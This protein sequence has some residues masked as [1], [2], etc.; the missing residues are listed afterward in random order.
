[1]RTHAR[2]VVIGGGV[3]GVSTLYHLAKK[4]WSDSVLIERRELTS[5]STWHA[6]GLLP[7]FN[8]SYSV[9]QIHKYSVALYQTLEQE[10][11]L[12]PGLRQVSNI[13]LART[14]DRM[15][16]Y[17]YY[18][19]VA[20][21]IGVKVKF[22][23]PGEVKEIWPLCDVEGIIGAIQHP[24]DG[25]IQPA[26]LTQALARGARDRGAEI[27]RHTTV[28]AVERL[29]SGE[30]K[31]STDKGDVT[32]EHVVSATGNFARQTGRLVGI[33]VPVIPV[34]HQYIVTEAHPEI[35]KRKAQGLPEMGVLR[36]SDSAWYMR[37]E[38]GGLLLGPYEK[39]APACY[40]NGPSSVSE[41][42]LFPEDLDR[43]APHIETA[44]ARVPAFG[45][46][47]VKKVYNGAIAYTPD[48][49][50]IVGPAPG[51]RNF[52]LN[53][54]HS[55]G[56]TAAGG[57]GWQLAEWIVEGE[58]TIDMLGVDPR[59]FGPY[60]DTG[61]L[62]EKNEEAY[63]K[64]FTVHYPDEERAAA[65]PLR[66]TPCYG[67]MKDL[68]AVFGSVYGWERPNW[69]APQGYG[70]S[71]ADLVQPDVL[72]NENHPAVSLGEKPRE[73]WSFRRS[74]Y[75]RFVGDECRNVHENVGLMDMSAFAKCEVSGP[76]AESWL[77][78]ILTNSVP[79][80]I[81]RVTLTYLLTERGGVRAEFT[82]TRIGPERFYLISAGALET[83]DFDV[84]EKL[85]PADNSVRLDKVTTQRGV[86]V[87]AGPR[88][89]EALAKVA[90]ID[91][92]SKAF[93]WLT[94]RRLSIK[95]AGVIAMR[96]NFVGEL[97]YE[98]H[99]PIEMQNAIFDALMAAG[100]PFGVKPFGIRA[101]DSLRLEKSYKLV[102]RELSI[103][104]AALESDL[105]RF[106]DFDKGPFLGR[107]ALVAWKGRGFANRLVTLEVQGVTDA[108]ARGSEPV[109]K[110]GEMIGR[111]TSGGYGWRTGKSL[112]LAMVK[113]EFSRIGDEVDVRILGETRRAIVIPDS[114]YDPA[115][116]ALRA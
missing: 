116:A 107:E 83:H 94:A 103:E 55:F 31:V 3:V 16:E 108:D 53:E 72:L 30:W 19:G 87:L 8:L 90:D 52:W 28:T 98:L 22:L 11:G 13:R 32:C 25:Y 73:K 18:A 115:N 75:F 68:G 14:R 67:R 70:L 35:V 111:T 40:V 27:N 7:L 54:G 109:T 42:E 66:Q 84:L 10:T 1:M 79:K 77:N 48:G 80:A 62:M 15:D 44:I 93:P 34:E 29:P 58:P 36:E 88:S 45:E 50:P 57:A 102:G 24:E 20:E 113:P 105:Q 59:R 85:L 63:A 89:R 76:G 43:L 33:N 97:G 106:V 26:D 41:Y 95:A 69:F 99:H 21:T 101:M 6:A 96:V 112:A 51:V 92:S 4:G 64:V 12:D 91:V 49:S 71:E 110:N 37:E 38:A 104:Y 81:G 78:S 56:V 65:R 5:G 23:S 61:Y 86:L 46:V 39:G 2:A 74:N 9:G 100:A 17:T 47:G 114:P 82:L 60:A